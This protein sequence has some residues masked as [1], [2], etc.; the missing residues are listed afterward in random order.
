M[1]NGWVVAAAVGLAAACAPQPDA[2]EQTEA[3]AQPAATGSASP[4]A[5][6]LRTTLQRSIALADS[7]EDLLRPVPLMR[8]NQEAA[9]RRYANAAHVARARSLGVHAVDDA[10]I[11]AARQAGEL[12]PLED[13]TAH[14]IVREGVGERALVT[15]DVPRMLRELGRRFQAELGQ[16]GLPPYRLEITSVLRT[17]AGQAALRQRNPNA[18]AGTSSHEFGTTLDIAYEAFAPPAEVPAAALPDDVP[19]ELRPELERV[20]ALALESVSGRKSREL[21]AILAEVLTSMQSQGDLLA[22]LERLQPV[23]HITVGRRFEEA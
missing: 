23:F 4:A 13:S 20:A 3:A 12:V 9:L 6:A 8:P 1:T 10:R 18:A 15:P 2:E 16:R 11:S 22:I 17:A 19:A 7:V 5:V 21:K 14:W